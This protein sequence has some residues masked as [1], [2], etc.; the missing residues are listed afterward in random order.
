MADLRCLMPLLQRKVANTSELWVI[1]RHELFRETKK[2]KYCHITL[3]VAEVDVDDTSQVSG[4]SNCQL[5][6]NRFCLMI[7]LQNQHGNLMIVLQNQ[8]RH[9]AMT[10]LTKTKDVM[11]SEE[12]LRFG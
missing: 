10:N 6:A 5:Q 2:R 9:T 3:I 12:E 4:H 8:H 1:I 7:V 11:V